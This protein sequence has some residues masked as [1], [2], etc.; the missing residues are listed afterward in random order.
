[1]VTDP[2]GAT[3]AVMAEVQVGA[4]VVVAGVTVALVAGVTA[5][6]VAEEP[7]EFAGQAIAAGPGRRYRR[8]DNWVI[9]LF[10]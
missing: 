7:G 5:A 6:T 2:A 9:N 10:C 1:M 4:T 3:V 8:S